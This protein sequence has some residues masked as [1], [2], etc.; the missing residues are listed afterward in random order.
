M[1]G[2]NDLSSSISGCDCF[3]VKLL[4]TPNKRF[5]VFSVGT[6]NENINQSIEKMLKLGY[7]ARCWAMLTSV[8]LWHEAYNK[9]DYPLSTQNEFTEVNHFSWPISLLRHFYDDLIVKNKCHPASLMS[10]CLRFGSCPS[11]AKQ[12]PELW[13]WSEVS[14]LW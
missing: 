7:Y 9:S 13:S 4:N 2:V 5:F 14:L 6:V 1:C 10:H 11:P 8:I 3:Y 12:Q